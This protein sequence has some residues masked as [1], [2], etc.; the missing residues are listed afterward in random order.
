M[1]IAVDPQLQL[2]GESIIDNADL[3]R[4]L[5]DRQQRKQTLAAYRKAFR[6]VDQAARG[7]LEALSLEPGRYR[8]GVF[9]I[10][11]E[12]RPGR[13]VSFETDTRRT[14]KIVSPKEPK[15]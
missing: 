1:G 10:E 5:E 6:E 15:P 3:Q 12:D 11:V 8:C 9:V 14:I 7:Q 2:E 13:A 4:N